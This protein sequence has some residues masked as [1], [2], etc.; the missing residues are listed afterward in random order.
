M[1]A[2]TAPSLKPAATVPPSSWRPE[3]PPSGCRP[4]PLLRASGRGSL[5][6]TGCRDPSSAPAAAPP[7]SE[8]VAMTPALRS[9]A[10]APPL[11]WRPRLSLSSL[12]SRHLLR[13]GSRDSLAPAR[14]HCPFSTT[15][16]RLT[17]LI[18]ICGPT[19]GVLKFTASR[20]VSASSSRTSG[21]GARPDTVDAPA[22]RGLGCYY[23][24]FSYWCHYRFLGVAAPLLLPVPGLRS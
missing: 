16:A 13:A 21:P 9:P 1:L 24:P 15:M 7:S 2:A 3:L 6:P 5:S 23:H 20:R 18:N 19:G 17:H 22:T 10:A 4:Q 11:C 8:L 14:G 12:W